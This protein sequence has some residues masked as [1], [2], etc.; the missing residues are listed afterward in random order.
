MRTRII[1]GTIMAVLAGCMLV[2][3]LYLDPLYPFLLIVFLLLAL[4][5]CTELHR[6]LRAVPHRPPFWLCFGGVFAV[7]LANWPVHILDYWLGAP[8]SRR[9]TSASTRGSS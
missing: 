8:V 6:L 1:V 3:D 9:S 5:A 2:A 4:A 7:L